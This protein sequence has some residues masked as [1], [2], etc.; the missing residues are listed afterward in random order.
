MPDKAAAAAYTGAFSTGLLGWM[1]FQHWMA[2]LGF[3]L[4]VATFAVNAYYKHRQDKREERL[5]QAKLAA[6]RAQMGQIKE[7]E[8]DGVA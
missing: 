6:Q 7:R 4:G 8:P 2:L 5:M 1:T 3:L